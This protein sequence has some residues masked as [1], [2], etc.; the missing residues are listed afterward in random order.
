MVKV[1]K[2]K[3]KSKLESREKITFKGMKMQLVNDFLSEIRGQKRTKEHLEMAE[4]IKLSTHDFIY[5]HTSEILRVW[6][7]TTMINQ[8]L[9]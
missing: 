9:Q 1:L 5:R 3:T 4:R 6:L 7:Q 2:T 8:I